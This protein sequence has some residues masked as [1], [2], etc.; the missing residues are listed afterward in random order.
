[1]IRPELKKE[2]ESIAE[3]LN[4]NVSEGEASTKGVLLTLI[5]AI[6]TNQEALLANHIRV[7]TEKLA[8]ALCLRRA[9]RN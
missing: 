9:S 8:A 5:A 2:L 7:F 3:R 4:A 6:E 1:M